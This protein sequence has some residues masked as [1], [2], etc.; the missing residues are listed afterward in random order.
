[1]QIDRGYV[2]PYFVTNQERM[3][4]VIDDPYILITDKKVSAMADIL[5]RWRRSSRRERT[6]YWSP[7]T[8]R[9]RPLP[10]WS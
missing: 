10:P 6:S 8:S 9:E 3:E 7:R 4:A 2:S 1:M 5:R